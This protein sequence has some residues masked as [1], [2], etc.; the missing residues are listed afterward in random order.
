[1]PFATMAIARIKAYNT[2]LTAAQIAADYNAE[3]VAFPGQPI[4]TKVGYN[5]VSKAIT[6]DWTPNPGPGRSYRVETNSN[7]GNPGGWGAAATGLSAG[8]FTNS[9]STSQKFYRIKV[10]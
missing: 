7:L 5:P 9:A 10:D 6:F 2:N 1:V 3:K 4:I 8:P